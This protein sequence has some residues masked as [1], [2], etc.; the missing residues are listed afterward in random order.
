MAA[1]MLLG[2]LAHRGALLGADRAAIVWQGR[3]RTYG[4]LAARTRATAG[5]LAAAGVAEG[6]RVAVCSTNSP[7]VIETCLAAALLGAVVVPLNVRLNAAEIRF[8]V[9]DAG[10]TH[11]IVHPA[12]AA[13]VSDSGLGDRQVWAIGT[14]LDA[15]VA[16]ADPLPVDAPRPPDSAPCIHLYT[17]GTT[18][19]PKGCLLTQRGWLSSNANLAHALGVTYDDRLLG[20]FP[21]FHVAGF[22]IALAHLTMGATVV[23]PESTDTESLWRLVEER[24][25]TT[26]SLPGLRGA[27][28][29]PM[30]DK[31]DRRSIR[32]VFGG[33][34]MESTKTFDA[35]AD[36]V[37][38]AVFRGVYGSTE[39]GNF[40]TVST[41]S[42]ER[43]RPG[44]IGRPLFGFDAA[45]LGD[46]DAELPPGEP[47]ELG[48]RGC[49]TMVG[50]WNRPE[51]TEE[52]LRH[53]W[54]HT[55]D[56]MRLDADGF[57]YFVDRAKDMIKPG[58][59]NVYSIEVETV[60]LA[61]PAVLD[62]A[63]IGVPDHRWG[64][65]VKAIVVVAAGRDVRPEEL[66]A[67]CLEHLASFKRPRWYE[68]AAEI[69]RSATNKIVKK[70][71]R[72]AHD[73][74]RA[75]RLPE[76]S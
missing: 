41:A 53:G 50:Y 23:I 31:V 37:P 4:E 29:H 28:A 70:D 68:F 73:P 62:C 32:T 8:Q 48:L 21:F 67:H 76:R 16:A 47:G 34:N 65:A 75:V 14:E 35:L 25:L 60:L 9:E 15:A 7:E 46:D 72:A 74:A 22:G 51:A 5:L 71:L 64:E 12:L 54:L 2:D 52:A 63:V 33:A 30:A 57:L 24:G 38:G 42:E 26:I 49:S 39:A 61:H 59:E 43:E 69:P 58:G 6:S 66:D 11:G 10:V 56:L 40:V 27:L 3:T 1:G 18:G 44:T 36:V 45:I 55:G 17:S 20:L 19:T 13:L